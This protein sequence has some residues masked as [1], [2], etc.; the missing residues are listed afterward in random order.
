MILLSPQIPINKKKELINNVTIPVEDINQYSSNVQTALNDLNDHFKTLEYTCTHNNFI[1]PGHKLN[2]NQLNVDTYHTNIWKNTTTRNQFVNVIDTFFQRR[3]SFGLEKK[4]MIPS[5]PYTRSPPLHHTLNAIN[6][7]VFNGSWELT[8]SSLLKSLLANEDIIAIVNP[9][10]RFFDQSDPVHLRWSTNRDTYAQAIDNY[11]ESTCFKDL[12]SLYN[13]KRMSFTHN[14]LDVYSYLPQDFLAAFNYYHTVDDYKFICSRQNV[15]LTKRTNYRYRFSEI[16]QNNLISCDP[17]MMS[18]ITHDFQEPLKM[19]R[20]DK[21]LSTTATSDWTFEQAPTKRSFLKRPGT[22]IPCFYKQQVM[23]LDS[24]GEIQHKYAY[25]ATLLVNLSYERLKKYTAPLVYLNKLHRNAYT[26]ELIKYVDLEKYQHI[27]SQRNKTFIKYSF[28]N[29][30]NYETLAQMIGSVPHDAKLT[31][32]TPLSTSKLHSFV[33]QPQVDLTLE[34]KKRKLSTKFKRAKDTIENFKNSTTE[35]TREIS[36]CQSDIDNRTRAIQSW[37]NY[38]QEAQE[39]IAEKQALVI[40]KL[41]KIKAVYS[42]YGNTYDSFST[43]KQ[44]YND[45]NKDYDSVLRKNISEKK[46]EVP[47]FFKDYDSSDYEI[48]S[49]KFKYV[50]ANSSSKEILIDNNIQSFLKDFSKEIKITQVIFQTNA[51]FKIVPDNNHAKAVVGGPWVCKVTPNSLGIKLRDQSSFFGISPSRNR[52]QVHPHAGKNHLSTYN[53]YLRSYSN[54]ESAC[55]GEAQPLIYSAFQKNDLSYIIMACSVWLKC[56]NSTDV[57]GKHYKEFLPWTEYE[58]G[59]TNLLLPT[60]EEIEISLETHQM[61]PQQYIEPS[62][63]T[64]PLPEMQFVGETIIESE[65]PQTLQTRTTNL[66]V[67]NN[68]VSSPQEEQ[69]NSQPVYVRYTPPIS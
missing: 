19:L 41:E 62:D 3:T 18:E 48:I 16:S 28:A 47:S 50:G 10:Q 36:V 64:S 11:S 59:I 66:P 21:L 69:T 24:D 6:Q 42:S 58:S 63:P 27:V 40:S 2:E 65:N 61:E 44:H 17:E 25:V 29:A 12:T 33:M 22:V 4:D 60:E 57:W 52:M 30:Q 45:F 13:M 39:T 15:M 14:D 8:K 49:I 37:H 26:Q 7:S 5:N 23:V 43:I 31:Q 67:A 51:P 32:Y 55:L 54:Y 46:Y 53:D 38:I 68:D 9:M 1:S 20:L 35:L 56:A 34:K